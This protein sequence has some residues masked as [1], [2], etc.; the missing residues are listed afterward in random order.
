MEEL[1]SNGRTRMRETVEAVA[2][3]ETLEFNLGNDAGEGAANEE[4]DENVDDA[5][6]HL[7][8]NIVMKTFQSMITRRY[9]TLQLPPLVQ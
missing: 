5:Q 1:L 2:Q 4:T 9:I 3:S 6:L 8:R 7:K